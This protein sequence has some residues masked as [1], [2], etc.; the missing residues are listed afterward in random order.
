MTLI[1]VSCFKESISHKDK[2]S[3]F[4]TFYKH[5]RVCE[6]ICYRDVIP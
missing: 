2:R 3:T 5:S 6:T 4:S 1:C